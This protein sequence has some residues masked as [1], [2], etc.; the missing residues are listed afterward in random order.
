MRMIAQGD[1]P[2]ES[3]SSAC[4]P[5]WG[6]QT[7]VPKDTQVNRVTDSWHQCQS[8]LLRLDKPPT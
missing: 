6:Q 7:V 8:D 5:S 2:H 4:S 3:F 1:A